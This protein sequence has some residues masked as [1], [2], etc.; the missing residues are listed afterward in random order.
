M[1]GDPDG[2]RQVLDEAWEIAER[3]PMRLHMAEIQLT[4]ARL[5]IAEDG[6]QNAEGRGQ[7]SED[8]SQEP[9]GRDHEDVLGRVREYLAQARKIIEDCGYWRRKEELEDAEEAA[10][11][12]EMALK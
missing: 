9:E 11:Q 2:A 10:K 6:R 12:W 3:G 8:R 4:R 5:L 7:K 1:Q